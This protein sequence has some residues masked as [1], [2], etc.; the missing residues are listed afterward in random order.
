MGW[1]LPVA[2]LLTRSARSQQH[3]IVRHDDLG[4]TPSLFNAALIDKGAKG[5]PMDQ[6]PYRA[7]F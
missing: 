5:N 2:D 7:E 3:V 4:G 1:D 6:M